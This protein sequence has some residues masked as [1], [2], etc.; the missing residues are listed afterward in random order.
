MSEA[1]TAHG[2]VVYPA[3]TSEPQPAHAAV[4]GPRCDCRDGGT[5]GE[6]RYG[7]HRTIQLVRAL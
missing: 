4:G 6:P 7:F 1:R 2:V 3:T 5:F